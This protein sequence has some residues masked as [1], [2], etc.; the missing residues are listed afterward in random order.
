MGGAEGNTFPLVSPELSFRTA[1]PITA[2]KLGD[3]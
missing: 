3:D 2:G 1:E